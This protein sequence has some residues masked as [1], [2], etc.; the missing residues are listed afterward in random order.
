VRLVGLRA[1]NA[2][3]ALRPILA[4]PVRT[5]AQRVLRAQPDHAMANYL[6]GR[7]FLLM[8][9]LF[10]GGAPRAVG[11]LTTA[12]ASSP[13]GDTRA[14][15][16]LAEAQLACG[17]PDAARTALLRVISQTDDEGRGSA[18]LVR[19]QNALDHIPAPRAPANSG[20]VA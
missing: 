20:A 11:P 5:G 9:R 10:G 14:L 19:A 7:W 16:A 17:R 12:A 18:R 4:A 2:P 3:L 15:S 1:T 8:P 6:L 13:R